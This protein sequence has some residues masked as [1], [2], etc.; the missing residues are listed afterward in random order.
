MVHEQGVSNEV[1]WSDPQ[2]L[3]IFVAPFGSASEMEDEE[4]GGEDVS[5]SAVACAHE[6]MED[7]D[8]EV[9][10]VV[11]NVDGTAEEG[12]HPCGLFSMDEYETTIR[13]LN[14]LAPHTE[15]MQDLQKKFTLAVLTFFLVCTAFHAPTCHVGSI[16]TLAAPTGQLQPTFRFNILMLCGHAMPIATHLAT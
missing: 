6:A 14:A 11:A 10:T 4:W 2:P 7:L 12:Q 16:H 15:G 3:L 5:E 1:D 13:V 8:M 9:E